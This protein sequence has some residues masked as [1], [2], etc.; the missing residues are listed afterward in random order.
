MGSVIDDFFA[1]ERGEEVKVEEGPVKS[2]FVSIVGLPNAGKSTLLNALIGQKVAITSKKPQTTRNQIMAVYDEERGQIVFHD[3]PGITR[4]KINCPYIWNPWR[5]RLWETE[6]WFF[7]SW[8]P[9]NKRGR[10]KSRY[11]LF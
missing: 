8:M 10:R 2:G 9:P 4:Q 1:K 3:T 6:T 5:K 7:I 11:F